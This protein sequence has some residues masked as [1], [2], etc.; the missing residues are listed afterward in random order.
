MKI[1]VRVT[2]GVEEGTPLDDILSVA[3]DSST[4]LVPVSVLGWDF[5]CKIVEFRTGHGGRNIY[6]TEAMAAVASQEN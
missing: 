3:Q 2:I 6:V 1:G 4:Q 5:A